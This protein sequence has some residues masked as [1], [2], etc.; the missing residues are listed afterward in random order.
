LIQQSRASDAAGRPSS[1]P[2]D[3]PQ[4]LIAVLEGKHIKEMGTHGELIEQEGLYKRLY[5]VQQRLEPIAEMPLALEY[6][7]G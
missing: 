4:K 2:F 7:E 3:H 6:V 1:S 5:T